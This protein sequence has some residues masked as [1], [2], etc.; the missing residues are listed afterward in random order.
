MKL[1]EQNLNNIEALDNPQPGDYWNEMFCP[2]FIVVDVKGRDITVLSCM[3]GPDSY[4]RKHEINAKID[5]GDSWSFDYSRSMVVD[6]EWIEKAVKYD[7]IDSFVADVSRS[8]KTQTVVNEWR[9]WVQKDMRRQIQ[10]MEEK[11]KEFTGWKHLKEIEE[12]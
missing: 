2:Y 3:G 10:E 12:V 11:W 9:D 4:N 6:R 5:H 8:E 7:N 1:T